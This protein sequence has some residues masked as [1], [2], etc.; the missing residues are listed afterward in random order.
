VVPLRTF[1]MLRNNE[2]QVTK[3]THRVVYIYRWFTDV[4]TWRVRPHTRSR[5]PIKVCDVI[6]GSG[7]PCP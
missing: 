2:T 5:R 4:I 6:S 7:R 1:L 3:S